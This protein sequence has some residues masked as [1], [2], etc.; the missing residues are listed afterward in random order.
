MVDQYEGLIKDLQEQVLSLHNKHSQLSQEMKKK[1]EAARKLLSERDEEIKGLR[2]SQHQQLPVMHQAAPTS[3]LQQHA[4]V[5]DASK[6]EFAES[7]QDHPPS[8]SVPSTP[9]TKTHH[10]ISSHSNQVVQASNMVADP[11]RIEEILSSEEVSYCFKW[12]S[13]YLFKH[14]LYR[15]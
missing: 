15:L 10:V 4:H 12:S 3:Q 5:T 14:T 9:R 8:L 11:A 1:S 6:N 2:L 7:K 13:C